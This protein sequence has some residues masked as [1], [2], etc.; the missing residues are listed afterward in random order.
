MKDKTEKDYLE[1]QI[2]IY[3]Y[4]NNTILKNILDVKNIN[5]IDM[6]VRIKSIYDKGFRRDMVIQADNELFLTEISVKGREPQ[7]HINDLKSDI[8]VLKDKGF[9]NIV[10]ITNSKCDAKKVKTELTKYI[11]ENNA[12]LIIVFLKYKGESYC[13]YRN[14]EEIKKFINNASIAIE[15]TWH[16]DGYSIDKSKLLKREDIY[17]LNNI[18][19]KG[20]EEILDDIRKETYYKNILNYKY[21][22]YNRVSFGLG[23]DSLNIVIKFNNKNNTLKLGVY[24]AEKHKSLIENIKLNLNDNWDNYDL[25]SNYANEIIRI[26]KNIDKILKIVLDQE[27]NLSTN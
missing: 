15:N 25:K 18:N 7:K 27:I 23:R 2:E 24:G 6:Q 12:K 11:E 8:C 17:E 3:L 9:R 13:D 19:N 20:I 1:Q 10:Y 14:I 26:N 16:I 4:K 21:I 5:R 22:K